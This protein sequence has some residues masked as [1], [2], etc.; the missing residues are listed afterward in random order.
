MKTKT[1]SEL[2]TI[3]R[4]DWTKMYFGA[5]PYWEAMTV[6]YQ[7]DPKQ[8]QFGWDSG[9]SIILYFLSNARTWKGETARAVKAELKRR[10]K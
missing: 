10:I 8:W 9:K 6:C 3:I 5:V 2:A 7:V 4:K 1:I